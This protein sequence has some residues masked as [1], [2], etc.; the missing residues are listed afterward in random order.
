MATPAS[1]SVTLNSAPGYAQLRTCGQCCAGYGL[2]Y[3][4]ERLTNAVAC[5]VNSCLCRTDIKP[6][7]LNHLSTCIASACSS[8]TN[9]ITSYQSVYLAYCDL[10]HGNQYSAFT[11]VVAFTTT[12]LPAGTATIVRTATLTQ[13]ASTITMTTTLVPTRMLK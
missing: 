1:E 4:S 2:C 5:K 13:P 7:A 9:D 3:D 6:L 10:D 8:N 12:S 11:N